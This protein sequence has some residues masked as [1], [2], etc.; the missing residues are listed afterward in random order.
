[1]RTNPERPVS[2]RAAKRSAL[3][4]AALCLAAASG[5]TLGGCRA[6]T[7]SGAGTTAPASGSAAT[8]AGQAVV[9]YGVPI[10]SAVTPAGRAADGTVTVSGAVRTYRLYVPASLP[11]NKPA[12]LLIALHGGLGSGPQFEQQTGF[13]G[14]AEANRFIVVY[15]TGTPIRPGSGEYVWNAGACCS[16]AAQNEENVNDVGFIAALI[17]KLE[18]RFDIDPHRVFVTGHSNGAMLGER[19][20]CQLSDQIAAIAVQS[21]TLV[22]GQC[23]PSEPVAVL[24]IHGTADQNVPINGGVG[25]KSLNKENYP[26]PADGLQILAARDGCP[27]TPTNQ[28]DKANSAVNFEIWHPCRAGTVVVWAKVTGANHAWMG[29][30]ASR[31]S[32]LRQGGTPYMGFDSSAVAWSFLAAHPR[33]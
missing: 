32:E 8:A 11:R 26:P 28:G 13:D 25:P 31:A 3:R 27:R 33:P 29:H 1:M 23:T 19:L 24:E 10:N 18:A 4:A 7:T 2:R 14:L 21:G 30:P 12:P 5:L 20:A 6:S 22:T 16:V 9:P 15:P 17:T